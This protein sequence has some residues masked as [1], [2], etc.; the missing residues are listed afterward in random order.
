MIRVFVII[1]CF[2][3]CVVLTLYTCDDDDVYICIVVQVA[4]W[5]AIMIGVFFIMFWFC[6]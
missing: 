2:I 3:V 1:I 5:Y 4:V 6:L